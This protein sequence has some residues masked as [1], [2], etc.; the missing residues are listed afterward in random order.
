MYKET[1]KAMRAH[2]ADMRD[3][4]RDIPGMK[5]ENNKVVLLGSKNGV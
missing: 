1:T 5:A 4:I 2:M 3:S